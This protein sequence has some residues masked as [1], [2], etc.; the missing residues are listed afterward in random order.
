MS[1]LLLK[2]HNHARKGCRVLRPSE[3]EPSSHKSDLLRVRQHDV[4]KPAC[5]RSGRKQEN[6]Q[7]CLQCTLQKW[8]NSRSIW[9]ITE[10]SMPTPR[11]EQSRSAIYRPSQW[12]RIECET[13]F[14]IQHGVY[15]RRGSPLFGRRTEMHRCFHF[16]PSKGVKYLRSLRDTLLR[17]EPPLWF[18]PSRR[19]C[20]GA[21]PIS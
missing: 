6:C 9:G 3:F 19:R 2:N 14:C 17:L 8:S 5:I 16:L 18:W 12:A 4:M 13:K 11:N 1:P 15:V 7:F 10:H 20:G 21:G